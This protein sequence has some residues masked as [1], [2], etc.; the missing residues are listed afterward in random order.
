MSFLDILS[1][2]QNCNSEFATLEQG[3]LQVLG[4]ARPCLWDKSV[5]AIPNR[6]SVPERLTKTMLTGAY[7]IY[8]E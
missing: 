6:T 5:S 2:K 7:A 3:I 1:Y 8:S 4:G